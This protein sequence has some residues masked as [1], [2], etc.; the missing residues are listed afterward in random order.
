MGVGGFAL[1][2]FRKKALNALYPHWVDFITFAII[3]PARFYNHE[4]G[5]TILLKPF[6]PL[7]WYCL[8][9]TFILFFLLN[10]FK[11]LLN[12]T[13]QLNETNDK[14]KL[15]F[16]NRNLVWINWS[17]LFGQPIKQFKL[18]DLSIKL[19]IGSWL[20]AVILLRNFYGG[21]LCAINIRP[22]W[23]KLNTIEKFVDAC[24]SKRI[25]P[26]AR[27]ESIFQK[28]LIVSN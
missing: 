22:S 27:L 2:Y 18:I 16:M 1:T 4:F 20:L 24:E 3:S 11:N 15:L 21:Y 10:Q 28:S 12:Q 25:I 13:I 17:Y 9:A 14:T 7:V 26:V 19:C 6:F 23:K 8:V 5:V